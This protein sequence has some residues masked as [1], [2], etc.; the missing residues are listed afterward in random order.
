M[1]VIAQ[2]VSLLVMVA[3]AGMVFLLLT[4]GSRVQAENGA[5]TELRIA[6]RAFINDVDHAGFVAVQ[7][8]TKVTLSSTKFLQDPVDSTKYLCRASTWFIAPA[9]E[10]LRAE[11]GDN[12]LMSLH[13]DIAIHDSDDC[14][15]P[16][17]STQHR[18][19][20]SAI[21]AD[22]TFIYE[23]LAQVP[24]DFSNGVVTTFREVDDDGDGTQD[25]EELAVFRAEHQVAAWYTDDEA[26]RELPRTIEAKLTAVFPVTDDNAASFK[27]TTNEAETELVGNNDDITDPGGEQTRW[28]PNSVSSLVISRS[29]SLGVV[30]GGE[31]EGLQ[32]AWAARP[33][34]EC[35]PGQRLTYSW[36]V[37]NLRTGKTSSGETTATTVQMTTGTG[38]SAEVWNGGTY[39]ASVAARCN[40]IDGQSGTTTQPSYTLPL[41]DVRMTGVTASADETSTTPSW[42]R[43]SSDPT[44]RYI[45]TYAP[46]VVSNSYVRS[47]IAGTEVYTYPG[48]PQTNE[49]SGS[50]TSALSL[51]KT[52]NKVVPGFPDTYFVRA[53]TAD[54]PNSSG[55]RVPAN[56]IYRSPGP[57][58]P[59]ITAL[60]ENSASWSAA[61]CPAGN[62][63]A[64]RSSTSNT[65]GGSDSTSLSGTG[66]SGTRTSFATIDQGSRVW[67]RVDARC[68][69]KYTLAPVN[70]QKTDSLSPW[71]DD[72][73][74]KWE[75]PIDAGENPGS[76]RTEFA[77]YGNDQVART[78]WNGIA[79]P[80]G[81]SLD[82]FH[83]YTRVNAQTG[84][85]AAT[86]LSGT[87]RDIAHGEAP[88]SYYEWHVQARCSSSASGA[89]MEGRTPWSAG[90]Y[91]TGVPSPSVSVTASDTRATSNQSV[92][93]Y[94]AASCVRQ[95][96]VQKSATRS[97]SRYSGTESFSG[98]AYC[99]GANGRTSGSVSDSVAVTWVMPA[100]SAPSSLSLSGYYSP[101]GGGAWMLV[102]LSASAGGSTNA[103]TYRS[104]VRASTIGFGYTGW[105][106]SLGCLDNT[107]SIQARGMAT[108]PGGS[109]TWT[110][111]AEQ[112]PT[113]L[114]R[115]NG[116]AC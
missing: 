92:A 70:G 46:A 20:V 49:V 67:L 21:T 95:T 58:A 61:T 50:P 51:T 87:T 35:S 43:V 82:Y 98:S 76:P 17:A 27:A 9:D 45:V 91:Y 78:A 56:Y 102:S 84:S 113:I 22:S 40:D 101:T 2:N 77:G 103:S 7:D 39:S 62:D 80:T 105:T 114:T 116:E 108:G 109:S 104:E 23:N 75:R 48:M 13:N 71:G 64:Y 79:C 41:P 73:L 44:T 111:G 54:S 88:G 42:N 97:V 55:L 28:I 68:S 16:V 86:W 19:A 12:T 89:H 69:T 63:H 85:F 25:D 4:G 1:V 60:N 29:P 32:L 8:D 47:T 100:P 30:V 57:A 6:N 59:S 110:T 14:E 18:V 83:E 107:S 3:L 38:G 37:K 90:G 34:S 81:T 93:I 115:T 10:R 74:A 72:A 52:G 15:S 31:R 24:L 94:T 11:R 53:S 112:Q 99:V 36:L 66:Q 33:A 65:Y 26:L 5:Q 106:A 96:S